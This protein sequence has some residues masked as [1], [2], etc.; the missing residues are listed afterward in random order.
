MFDGYGQRTDVDLDLLE[1]T[2]AGNQTVRLPPEIFYNLY[3][4][5]IL[6]YNTN[7]FQIGTWKLNTLTMTRP[8]ALE[9]GGI[10]DSIM[11]NK[12]F[13][14]LIALVEYQYTK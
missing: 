2:P 11:R 12:T 4:T 13:K 10:E 9:A 14:V 5:T 7:I 3:F 8:Y 1:L 6:Y